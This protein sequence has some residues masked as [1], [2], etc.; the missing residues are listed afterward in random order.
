MITIY[1][2]TQSLCARNLLKST[3]RSST[4][5]IPQTTGRRAALLLSTTPVVFAVLFADW[6]FVHTDAS[7]LMIRLQ[8]C[9]SCQLCVNWVNGEVA[10]A[11][12]ASK[13]PDKTQQTFKTRL[14][15]GCCGV[16]D[17]TAKRYY[18]CPAIKFL[19]I[20]RK[21]ALVFFFSLSCKI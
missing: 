20:S 13:K 4:L 14:F 7:Y 11:D 15:F 1:C 21:M 3:R 17:H 12:C 6:Y 18:C 2:V 10:P 16:N 9:V 8:C 5:V 19:S